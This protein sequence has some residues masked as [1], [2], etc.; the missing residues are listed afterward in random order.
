MPMET[1]PVTFNEMLTPSGL[2]IGHCRLTKVRALNALDMQMVTLLTKQLKKWQQDDAIVMVLL[3]GDGDRGFCAGGDVVSMFH[4]MKQAQSESSTASQSEFTLEAFFSLE[5]ELD[6]LIHTYTKPV[7]VWGNGIVMGGGLGLM[8]GASHRIVTSSSRIAM[9]EITIGLYPDVGASYFLNKMPDGCGLFLGLT[10]ANINA[11]DALYTGLADYFVTDDLKLEFFEKL[12]SNHWQTVSAHKTLDNICKT[13]QNRSVKHLPESHLKPYQNWLHELSD[14]PTLEAVVN[15][16]KGKASEHDPWL[17]KGQKALSN[18]SAV[19][20]HIVFEQLRRGKNMSLAECL[21][22]ELGLSCKS[23][24]FGE[25]Q[26]GVRALLV[27]KDGKPNWKYKTVEEVPE[28]VVK[29]FFE[30]IWS[31][32]SH[33]L[34][35][36]R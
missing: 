14:L 29:Y 28:S 27:D 12:L 3:D 18:G 1:T 34:Q 10:A 35:H 20:A 19:A 32:E 22:M 21:R 7:V 8:C 33:P 25:F 5:Y 24:E 23:G 26:E 15:A 4:A 11:A 2:K 36:L 6:H 30:A 31:A 16:I 9:P 13:F 17:I